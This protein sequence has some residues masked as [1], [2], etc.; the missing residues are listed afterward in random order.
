MLSILADAAASPTIPEWLQLLLASGIVA[1]AVP[2]FTKQLGKARDRRR[3]A[4]TA[5]VLK[6]AADIKELRSDMN[7][8]NG[9]LLG[10]K[11][12]FTGEYV[13]D[14]FKDTFPVFQKEV[15]DRLEALRVGNAK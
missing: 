11:S 1:I 4:K 5:P 9:W 6:D 14:G 2:A 12:P 15:L 13:G 3:A 8:V 7:R 10:N